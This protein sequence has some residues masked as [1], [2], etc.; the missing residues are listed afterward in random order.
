MG[1]EMKSRSNN[2]KKK[3]AADATD[4]NNDMHAHRN[5]GGKKKGLKG[6]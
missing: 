3:I 5:E 6:F 2:G 1:K 4:L